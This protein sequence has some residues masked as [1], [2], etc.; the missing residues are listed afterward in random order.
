VVARRRPR[1]RV[2]RLPGVDDVAGVAILGLP[3]SVEEPFLGRRAPRVGG[4][5]NCA[6]R[7]HRELGA[8]R[9]PIVPRAPLLADVG[10]RASGLLDGRLLDERLRL[11]VQVPRLGRRGG[12]HG[13]QKCRGGNELLA[14][15]R[16]RVRIVDIEVSIDAIASLPAQLGRTFPARGG[17]SRDGGAKQP[18]HAVLFRQLGLELAFLGQL[19]VDVGPLGDEREER[20]APQPGAV[21]FP[22]QQEPLR[23][24]HPPRRRCLLGR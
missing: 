6:A 3:A 19:C 9:T 14:C 8:L 12:G 1:L 11:A 7:V 5:L 18:H 4:A 13:P 16:G 10:R 17:F 2:T 21:Q 24:R 15:S 23:R 22:E 20:L